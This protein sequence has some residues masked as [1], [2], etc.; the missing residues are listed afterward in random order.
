MFTGTSRDGQL[1]GLRDRVRLET[2]CDL[3][4]VAV[5]E[6]LVSSRYNRV[7]MIPSV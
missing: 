5:L 6:S 1:A 4:E 3:P 7:R 2:G